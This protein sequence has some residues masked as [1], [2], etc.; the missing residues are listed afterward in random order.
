MVGPLEWN[1]RGYS[2]TLRLIVAA[3]LVELV[4]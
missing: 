3:I 4:R 2:G 1:H